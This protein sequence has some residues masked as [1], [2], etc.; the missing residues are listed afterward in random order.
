VELIVI[1]VN[2]VNSQ[3]E[4]AAQ[5]LEALSNKKN[6]STFKNIQSTARALA[7]E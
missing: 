1:F 4:K 7:R 5:Y 2:S 6:K 3:L